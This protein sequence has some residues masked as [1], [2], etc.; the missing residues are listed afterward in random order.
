[1]KAIRKHHN[2]KVGDK[3]F[4]V[5]NYTFFVLFT[6]VCIYP[7]YYILMYSFSDPQTAATKMI[8]LLPV[9]PTILNYVQMLS[10]EGIFHAFLIS[11]ARTVVGTTITVLVTALFAFVITQPNLPARKFFYRASIVS[12]YLNAGIIPWYLTMLKYGLKNNFLLYVI[13][14]VVNA[15]FMVLI[16]TYLEAIPKSMEESALMDGAGFFTVFFKI[17]LPVCKPV[18]AAVA[19][20]GAVGQWNSWFDNFMLVDDPNLNTLQNLLLTVLNRSD[21][22]VQSIRN[23]SGMITADPTLLQH[24]QRLTPMGLKMTLSVIVTLPVLF[25]Y[26]FLQRYFVKGIM[27]GAVKE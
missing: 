5:C 3:V 21:A 22:L 6:L 12:M 17:V 18:I 9:E 14:G 27:L 10:T 1:M 26:P 13:P 7:F 23:G 25:V 2:S 8:T 19:V 20:Y 4:S 15:Y 24:A 11:L 16:K